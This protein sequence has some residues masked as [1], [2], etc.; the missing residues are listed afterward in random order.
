MKQW[1]QLIKSY[2]RHCIQANSY[3]GDGIHSPFAFSF[4]TDIKNEKHPYYAYKSIEDIRK[5]LLK[6]TTVIH[7]TDYGTGKSRPRRVCDIAKY[8]AKPAKQAQL[9]FRL[10]NTFQ[11]Q[12]IFDLG[13]CI[14]T[15]TLYL[16]KGNTQAQ[17]HTFEGCPQTAQIAETCF[18]QAAC[19]NIQ[20]HIGNIN[21]TLPHALKNVDQ[22]DFVF[23][24]ANHQKEPTLRYFNQCLEKA[25]T[26]SIF[27]FDDIHWSKGMEEAWNTIKLHPKVRVSIDLYHI[28]ILFFNNELK[29]QHY[30]IKW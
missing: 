9:L 7:V 20:L 29:T 18:R 25:T 19:N 5:S 8:S 13:T 10:V 24:D 26:R 6:D 12:T 30:Q 28:G 15:T 21:Q 11:P 23:F 4:I 3:R 22:V 17:I 2:C 16:A 14:G 1:W 27:V